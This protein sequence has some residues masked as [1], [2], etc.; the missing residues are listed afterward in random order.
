M[1]GG[2]V[3]D[4]LMG[5]MPKDVD[6]AFEGCGQDFIDAFPEAQKVGKSVQVWLLHGREYMPLQGN[7]IAQDLKYR[8]LTINALAL[9]ENGVLFTHPLAL[10]DI[11]NGLLRPASAHA[12]FDD[13]TRIYR[14][15]RFAAYYPHFHVH[16]EALEQAQAV[17]QQALHATLPAER[18]GREVFK[19]LQS[20]KPSRFFTTLKAAQALHPWF[21]ELNTLSAPHRTLWEQSMDAYTQSTFANAQQ[22]PHQWAML[23]WMFLG[24][25]WKKEKEQRSHSLQEYT[26]HNLGERL[27]LP[28]SFSKA[29]H[30]MTQF[31]AQACTLEKLPAEE[32]VHLILSVHKAG[33]SELFWLATDY[34]GSML[35]SKDIY[36]PQSP[37]ALAVLRV[38]MA[39]HLPEQWQNQGV[40]SGQKLFHMQVQALQNALRDQKIRKSTE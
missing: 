33:L 40:A 6:M 3:R 32:Q 28:L 9:D 23:R 22:S 24:A 20:A 14:L 7:S 16:A 35:P 11:K 34:L 29:A 10:F 25:F 13:A 39:V 31:F 17:T 36:M 4:L 30:V 21:T 18:V 8:D 1:V 12:F 37:H 2:A 38:I 19:A 15:A 26:L 27:H 5:R